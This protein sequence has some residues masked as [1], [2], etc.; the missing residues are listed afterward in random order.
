MSNSLF[1]VPATRR[2][3]SRAHQLLAVVLISSV[4][5]TVMP[6]LAA[7]ET[8][9]PGADRPGPVLTTHDDNPSVV[10]YN[11][12]ISLFLDKKFPAALEEMRAAVRAD[13]FGY[14]T[15]GLA[16]S[17]LCLMY[18]KVGKYKNAQ[19]SCSKALLVLPAY[20]PATINL[21]RAKEHTAPPAE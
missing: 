10:A 3:C 6:A 2:A 13:R 17:N 1:H 16:F 7:D 14:P 21:A 4:L 15:V 19:A 11:K 5:S 12:A 18:L 9:F 8:E 20:I